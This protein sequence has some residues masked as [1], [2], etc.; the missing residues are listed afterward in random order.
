MNTAHVGLGPIG[1]RIVE[2]TAALDGP[3]VVAVIDKDPEKVGTSVA[4][5][6][7]RDDLG[8]A[9][10]ACDADVV[11]L[12]TSSKLAA[13]V[14]DVRTAA[15]HGVDVVATT[16]EL[17]YPW[18][19]HPGVAAEIDAIARDAG[20]TVLGTGVN[21]GFVMD[22]L[23]A[24]ATAACT[25]VQSVKVMRLVDLR[26]R[27]D[28]LKEKM[29]VGLTEAQFRERAAA[30]LLGH[31]G[32]VE[33]VHLVADALGWE[34]EGVPERSLEP[35]LRSG[36]VIGIHEEVLARD[37]QGRTLELVLEMNLEA[38]DARDEI[39]IDATPPVRLVVPGGIGGD[40]ATAALVVNY[41][42]VACDAAPGLQT[43]DRL[44]PA[45]SWTG[46]DR[47]TAGAAAA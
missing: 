29:A 28:Q 45:A 11:V 35:V 14:E 19:A 26:T 22:N 39:V 37:A 30:G 41:L 47:R 9:L 13:I 36:E 7:V 25:G 38:D 21:P 40:A 43:V 10:A 44:R 20:I 16:E 3:E 34:L 5:V 2:Y 27:R 12:A 31:V 24:F 15:A 17:S 4:G 8:A 18:H 46:G 32:L 23:T 1:L 6:Q 33:S 42:P